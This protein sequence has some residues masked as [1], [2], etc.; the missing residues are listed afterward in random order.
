MSAVL[1]WDRRKVG[2]TSWSFD[3][4]NSFSYSI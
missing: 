1:F 4:P 3:E 2:T